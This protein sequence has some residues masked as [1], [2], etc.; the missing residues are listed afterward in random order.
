[1]VYNFTVVL[2]FKYYVSY[3]YKNLPNQELFYEQRNEIEIEILLNS[4]RARKQVTVPEK[5]NPDRSKTRHVVTCLL[6]QFCRIMI[7]RKGWFDVAIYRQFT[8]VA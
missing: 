3:K 6:G 8:I 7:Q 5:T 2:L 1:M 4:Q